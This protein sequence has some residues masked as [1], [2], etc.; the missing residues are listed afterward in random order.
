MVV[1][2]SYKAWINSR[3]L[4]DYLNCLKR[5]YD[6]KVSNVLAGTFLTEVVY[7]VS[8]QAIMKTTEKITKVT[9]TVV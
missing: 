5:K 8:S 2:K 6:N 9:T 3:L 4:L 7:P 1:L